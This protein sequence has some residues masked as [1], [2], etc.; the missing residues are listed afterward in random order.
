MC[1]VLFGSIPNWL[2][3]IR[4]LGDIFPMVGLFLFLIG[5]LT[6]IDYIYRL[7][8]DNYLLLVTYR[9]GI[10]IHS[11]N[12]ENQSEIKVEENLISGLLTTINIIFSNVLLSKSHI[13]T[14][15]SS[16]AT[17]FMTTGKYITTTILTQHTSAILAR[18]MQRYTRE[19]EIQF[20]E[21]LKKNESDASQFDQAK[22]L[23]SSVF[24]FFII[25]N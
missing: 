2:D 22:N 4:D 1:I 18:A 9:S 14:I 24:P 19:F 6:N 8:Y 13:D 23:L 3:A 7:P 11:V 15:A 25:R 20:E 5:Y 21:L 10:T 12:I 16:D 17:I